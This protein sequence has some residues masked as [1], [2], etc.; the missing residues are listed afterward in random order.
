MAHSL[1]CNL[2]SFRPKL[3]H[4]SLIKSAT[5]HDLGYLKQGRTK[6]HNNCNRPSCTKIHCHNSLHQLISSMWLWGKKIENN[7]HQSPTGKEQNSSK[8]PK[9]KILK[10]ERFETYIDIDTYI[11]IYNDIYTHTHSHIHIHT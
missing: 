10:V 2:S 7:K 6:H 8:Q 4:V 9:C 3:T 11:H 5:V 1:V